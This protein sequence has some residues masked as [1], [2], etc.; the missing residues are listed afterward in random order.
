MQRRPVRLAGQ[1][2]AESPEVHAPRAQFFEPSLECLSD[3]R[4]AQSV[5]P[6]AAP[7]PTL[8]SVAA[9]EIGVTR[10]DV[11]EA[12]HVDAVGAIADHAAVGPA[13]K[14]AVRATPLDV[15][16]DVAADLVARVGEPR[17]EQNAGA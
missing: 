6:A 10:R 16:H 9:N 11:A 15:V 3:P 7:C 5:L 13:L 12:R 14:L 2:F 1:H 17:V 4:G 8:E